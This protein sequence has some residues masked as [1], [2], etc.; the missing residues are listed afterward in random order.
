M[1]RAL[2]WLLLLAVAWFGGCQYQKNREL[3]ADVHRL[4]ERLAGF[5]DQVAVVDTAYVTD[6]V[7]LTRWRTRLDTMSVDKR[8]TDTVW[9][10]QY[11]QVAESTVVACSGAL[12]TCEKRVALRDSM[13]TNLDSLLRIE[14]KRGPD[15]K[16]KLGWLLAGAAAGALVPR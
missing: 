12:E 1:T 4:E 13:I 10:K 14:R 3:G 15:W 11:V 2:P 8:I 9:V 6:T 5:H 16:S 7:T